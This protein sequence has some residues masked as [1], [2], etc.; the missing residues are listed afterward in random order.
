MSENIRF[1]PWNE[2]M[3]VLEEARE[4]IRL[5]G[6]AKS[7]YPSQASVADKLIFEIQK[8]L[9]ERNTTKPYTVE[10][11]ALFSKAAELFR[12]CPPTRIMKPVEPKQR[13]YGV[14][15]GKLVRAQAGRRPIAP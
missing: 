5:L 15:I 8:I 13:I 1:E 7:I 2:Y 11:E 6:L 3:K 10:L 12:T 4:T 14:Q 9:K